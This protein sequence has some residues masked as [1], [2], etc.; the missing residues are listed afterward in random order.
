MFAAVLGGIYKRGFV[1][2]N[3]DKGNWGFTG[4]VR[5]DPVGKP[6][7]YIKARFLAFNFF[8][9]KA[10]K[11]G[12]GATIIVWQVGGET[13]TAYIVFPAGEIDIEEAF[14]QKRNGM[15]TPRTIYSLPSVGYVASGVRFGSIANG[16]ASLPLLP[17]LR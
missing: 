4:E 9:P 16:N 10:G 17:V 2:L 11:R 12:Q 6:K 5:P 13:Y 15:P 3:L 7:T 8:Q 14:N 1:R